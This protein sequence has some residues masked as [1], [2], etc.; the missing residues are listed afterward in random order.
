MSLCSASFSCLRVSFGKIFASCGCCLK[1][2]ARLMFFEM[3]SIFLTVYNEPAHLAHVFQPLHKHQGSLTQV[4][5]NG[6]ICTI[7]EIHEPTAQVRLTQS[8]VALMSKKSI[9]FDVSVIC[10]RRL[11]SHQNSPTYVKN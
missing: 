2:S 5:T 8:K 1:Y 6:C 4:N 10:L 11:K 7:V 9:L 3:H